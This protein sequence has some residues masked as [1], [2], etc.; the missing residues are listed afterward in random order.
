V[1]RSLGVRN[2][3]K[4]NQD[5]RQPSGPEDKSETKVLARFANPIRTRRPNMQVQPVPRSFQIR[6]YA[7]KREVKITTRIW[8]TN[9][10]N[11]LVDSE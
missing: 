3:V 9:P 11:Q 8:G 7:C 4:A 5:M 1:A 2:G 10:K 6:C